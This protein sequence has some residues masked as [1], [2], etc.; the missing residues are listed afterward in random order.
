[1][2][3]LRVEWYHS[4][5]DEPVERLTSDGTL[6]IRLVPLEPGSRAEIQTDLGRF[7]G[8][9]HRVLISRT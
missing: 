8:R 9:D 3:Y 2:R 1:M 7:C 5:P 4:D 6:T